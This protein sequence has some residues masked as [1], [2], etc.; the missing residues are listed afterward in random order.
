MRFK[1]DCLIT[2]SIVVRNSNTQGHFIVLRP[3]LSFHCD[4]KADDDA[5]AHRATR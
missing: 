3:I 1:D 2:T 4:I 5:W